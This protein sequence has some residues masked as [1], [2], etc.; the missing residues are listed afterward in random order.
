MQTAYLVVMRRLMDR[1]KPK[2]LQAAADVPGYLMLLLGIFVSDMRLHICLRQCFGIAFL[3]LL[4][5]P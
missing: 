2:D 1:P 3:P 4:M 5:T